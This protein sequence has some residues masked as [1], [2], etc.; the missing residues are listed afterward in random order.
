MRW[1]SLTNSSN[2][3]SLNVTVYNSTATIYSQYWSSVPTLPT[4][5]VQFSPSPM[6]DGK[7]AIWMEIK[8]T[9]GAT[10]GQKSVFTF[11]MKVENP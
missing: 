10:P 3:A 7:Y 11:E 6:A 2:I 8:A 9:S 1:Y 5:F 4:G